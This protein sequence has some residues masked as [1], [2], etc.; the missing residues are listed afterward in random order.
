[1][2]VKALDK[3]NAQVV[4]GPVFVKLVPQGEGHGGDM[5]EGFLRS[6]QSEMTRS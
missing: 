5:S 4:L 2:S 3:V 1:M 6:G